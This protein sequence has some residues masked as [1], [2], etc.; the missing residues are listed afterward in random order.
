LKTAIDT[1]DTVL[2]QDQAFPDYPNFP[3]AAWPQV[4]SS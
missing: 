4:T 1:L 3:N 2:F